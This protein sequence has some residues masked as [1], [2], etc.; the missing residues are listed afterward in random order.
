MH[1]DMG[2]RLRSANRTNIGWQLIKTASLVR[3]GLRH[4]A[5]L[6]V[7]SIAHL[8]IIG[9]GAGRLVARF[10]VFE[11]A[12]KIAFFGHCYNLGLLFVC[13]LCTVK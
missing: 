7:E 11:L 4:L 2:S 12:Q 5:L 9:A 6:P 1:V 8:V 3:E 13:L 10:F